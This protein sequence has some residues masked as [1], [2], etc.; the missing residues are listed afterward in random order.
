V[1]F[2]QSRFLYPSTLTAIIQETPWLDASRER[3]MVEVEVEVDD[4]ALRATGASG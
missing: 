4:D 2:P 1:E 3:R